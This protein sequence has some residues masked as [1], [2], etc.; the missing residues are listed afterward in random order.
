MKGLS[1][2]NTLRVL[3]QEGLLQPKSC[4]E[5]YA[6]RCWSVARR[7]CQTNANRDAIGASTAA[8]WFGNL[9]ILI[10]SAKRR[11]RGD[12]RSRTAIPKLNAHSL[13]NGLFVVGERSSPFK[14]QLT[15]ST[16][17]ENFPSAPLR[18][19]RIH[20]LVPNGKVRWLPVAH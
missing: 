5:L 11:R 14:W 4:V 19:L 17:F 20:Y 10:Y 1:P 2:P 8:A 16:R 15:N 18:L 9:I 6:E 13:S 12:D 3:T 7:P